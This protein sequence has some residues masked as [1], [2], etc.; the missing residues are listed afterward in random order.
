MLIRGAIIALLDPTLISLC[1]GRWTFQVLFAIGVSMMCMAPL[2]RLSTR[3]L[4]TLSLGWI[5]LGE[6]VTG[7]CWTPPGNSSALAA[8]T[9]ETYG[10]PTL[11][12]KYAVL[13][14]LAVMIL[15]WVFGRHLIHFATGQSETSGKKVLWIS[16]VAGLLIFFVVRSI[17]DY[18]DMF[19]HR[20]DNSW[21][22]WLH[23]SKYPPSI[24]YYAL[25]LGTL[26]LL[27]ALLRTIELRIGVRQNGC[28]TSSDKLRCSTTWCIA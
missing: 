15:G 3:A 12:I 10:T 21:Q 17:A 19:L 23:V 8:F 13:P 18:G 22:R 4:L 24:T 6:I 9:V 14:W 16:G 26:F 2:R 11:N 1:S 28:F 7:L 27:L 25:E 5:A 20:S